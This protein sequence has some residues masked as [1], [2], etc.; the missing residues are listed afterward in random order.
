VSSP[1]ILLN[2]FCRQ[3]DEVGPDALAAVDAVGKSG[4]YI[5]GDSVASF[6]AVLATLFQR[7]LA[8]GCA[9][10]LDA[11]EIG[12]RALGLLPGEK[13]LTTPLSAFA[14]TLAIVR[15]G[16]VPLYIDV[17]SRGALDLDL[18]RRVLDARPDVRWM[19]PVH[20]YGHPMDLERLWA[21]KT[22]LELSVVEDCAQCVGSSL[23]ERKVGTVGDAAAVS[24]YPTKNLGTLG[25]GGAVLMSDPAL[26]DA[27][28]SL[29]NYGQSARYF[30][31]RLGL[32]SRLDE[33]HAAM[34]ERALLPRLTR[35]TERRQRVATR[36]L[37]EIE[38]TEV[39]PIAPA[40]SAN[41]VW[42]LFPVLVP[43]E[44]RQDFQDHL[45]RAG[46]QTAIHYPRLIP[47]QSALAGQVPFEVVGDLGNARRF[48]Q[49]EVS[50][51]IHPYLV[52]DEVTAIVS[53]VNR[54]RTP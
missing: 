51:P 50:L 9:S 7:P 52:D 23:G 33:V 21:I 20:L 46:V 42:H 34:L 15:A 49:Q 22:R 48:A 36:F 6:E 47:E 40:R 32:N 54:W 53:A 24:F 3:W 28:L 39:K 5:L 26:R 2:D 19:V 4:K 10:G 35:W 14:T 38:H 37:A 16:G 44:A 30:H 12:L 43:S 45:L 29:R 11:I 18:A 41:S 27:C 31:D 1:S 25:D 17:D 8:V 13:V